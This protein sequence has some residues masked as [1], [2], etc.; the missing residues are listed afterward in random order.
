MP[1]VHFTPSPLSASHHPALRFDTEI[2]KVLT[3]LLWEDGLGGEGDKVGAQIP[4][5]P[6]ATM[7][8][9]QPTPGAATGC[10]VHIWIC[11]LPPFPGL[12]EEGIAQ[13]PNRREGDD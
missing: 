5:P 1:R 6:S 4:T 2:A 8:Q 9:Q 10:H 3:S 7:Q 12:L 11:L 13:V